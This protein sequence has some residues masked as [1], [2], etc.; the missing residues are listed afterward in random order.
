MVSKSIAFE[1]IE[2][3]GPNNLRDTLRTKLTKASEVFIAVAFVTEAGLDE[4]IQPLRQVASQGK[5]RLLTGLYQRVTEPKALKKLLRIQKETRGNFSVRLS[6]EPK[7]HRKV[8]VLE[9]RTRATAIVG[10]SNLTREGLRNGGELDMMVSLSPSSSSYK[11]LKKALEKDWNKRRARPL[12]SGQIE[13]YESFRPDPVK[14]QSYPTGQLKIILG[15]EP[16]HEEATLKAEPIN[17][18]R[19][20]ITGF[21]KDRTERIIND[22]TNWD[23]KNYYWLS[24]YGPHAYKIGDRIFLYDFS[25]KRFELVGVKDITYTPISTPD[26]RHFIAFKNVGRHSRQFSISLWKEFERIGISKKE[27]HKTKMIND[28]IA[29]QLMGILNK[30]RSS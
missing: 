6:R 30:K 2:N 20:Y 4:I 21:V 29:K 5:V 13:R 26:G 15:A 22:H 24:T 27:A 3:S 11:R 23:E 1:V 10:S 28:K 16:I 7:F 12:T 17:Y 14:Q 9:N 18:W 8:F 19:D 25:T